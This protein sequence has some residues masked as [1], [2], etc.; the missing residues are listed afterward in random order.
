MR[1]I[2]KLAPDTSLSRDAIRLCEIRL[3]FELSQLQPQNISRPSSIVSIVS[4]HPAVFWSEPF[5]EPFPESF[6]GVYFILLRAIII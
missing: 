3:L 5:P 2:L 6:L 1:S 4:P